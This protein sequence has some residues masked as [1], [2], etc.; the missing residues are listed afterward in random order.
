MPLPQRLGKPI[1]G[2]AAL[3]PE[4]HS[5][6]TAKAPMNEGLGP[7]HGVGLLPRPAPGPWGMRRT[8]MILSLC[9]GLVLKKT[10]TCIQR[11]E[12]QSQWTRSWKLTPSA[13]PHEPLWGPHLPNMVGQ[14][15]LLHAVH[16]FPRHGLQLPVAQADVPSCV[17]GRLHSEGV[18]RGAS[19]RSLSLPL[20]L[21]SWYQSL[22]WPQR[23]TSLK[24]R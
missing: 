21:S 11:H 7:P 14:L 24:P 18:L 15:S 4:S 6:K 17:G 10:D 8:L 12:E 5:L 22:P 1:P 20:I 2:A 16:L 3:H 9:F 23:I 19:L 13:L